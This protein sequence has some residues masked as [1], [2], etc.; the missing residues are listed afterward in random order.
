MVRLIYSLI[1]L[2]YEFI[3]F[4]HEGDICYFRTDSSGQVYDINNNCYGMFVFANEKAIY[5]SAI[6]K[7]YKRHNN[8]L[9]KWL[10][11]PYETFIKGLFLYTNIAYTKRGS[12]I[13][14]QD[15]TELC[16]N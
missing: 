9:Y 16:Y 7:K 6:I 14:R 10:V 12:G 13:A 2:N 5:K 11:T 4:M 1:R 8:K 3:S 15:Q